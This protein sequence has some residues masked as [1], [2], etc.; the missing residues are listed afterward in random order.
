MFQRCDLFSRLVFVLNTFKSIFSGPYVSRTFVG[1]KGCSIEYKLS[2]VELVFRYF[3]IQW[4]FLTNDIRLSE[5]P[6]ILVRLYDALCEG[7]SFLFGAI[8]LTD[9][10]R[11]G[12]VNTNERINNLALQ[13]HSFCKGVL[14]FFVSTVYT[15]V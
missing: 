11:L 12:R 9:N 13:L 7:N 3:H 8:N 14:A 4:L 15:R 10:K 5:K 6:S 2:S 1:A